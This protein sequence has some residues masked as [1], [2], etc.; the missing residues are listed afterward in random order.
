MAVVDTAVPILRNLYKS[1]D[2]AIKI[3]AL[4]VRRH[5]LIIYK[6]QPYFNDQCCVIVSL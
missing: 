2:D 6:Y 3:R 5:L 4:V 1:G